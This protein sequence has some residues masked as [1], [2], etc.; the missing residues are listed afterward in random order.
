MDVADKII[1]QLRL[2]ANFA[3]GNTINV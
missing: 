3:A 2:N 1:D